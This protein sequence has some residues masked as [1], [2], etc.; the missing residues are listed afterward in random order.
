MKTKL[1]L[2]AFALAALSTINSQLSTAHAQGALTPSGA[3]APTMKTLAQV[4]PRTD[5]L[6]L[7]AGL[8]GAYSITQPGSY[9][10]SANLVSAPGV[11]GIEVKTNDVTIDL[12]GFALNGAGGIRGIAVNGNN[13][14]RL[15]VRNGKIT[16]YTSGIDG[17]GVLGTN[18]SLT[19]EDVQLVGF[20]GTGGKGI[21]GGDGLQVRRCQIST[22]NGNQGAAL[23]A[24]NLAQISD[25]LAQNNYTGIATGS[26]S[27]LRAVVARAHTTAFGI[28]VG[29]D[30]Q[31]VECEAAVNGGDGIIAGTGSRLA[32]C[33]AKKNSASGISIGA[34]VTVANCSALENSGQAGIYGSDNC[35]IRDC[36][37][38]LNLGR[39]I[40]AS[41]PASIQNCT[42]SGNSSRGIETGGYITGCTASLNGDTGIYVYG[43]NGRVV[44]NQCDGNLGATS[45]GIYVATAGVQVEGNTVTSQIG[46]GILIT[47][48]SANC[49][50]VANKAHGNGT[51]YLFT[52]LTTTFGS[53][54]T[55]SGGG[56]TNGVGA[57]ANFSY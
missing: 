42:V 32:H 16:G 34:N 7:S 51:N 28:F 31:L 41:P 47:G 12:R 53:I 56:I 27:L 29:P 50:V 36:I 6:T 48:G 35:L 26:N 45:A 1:L 44:N 21:T 4:E 46:T 33:L 8:N 18:H 30:S 38:N 52:P 13:F 2:T 20:S 14:Q 40:Q 57:W 22:F 15:A 23:T 19:V 11:S 37:A 25:C 43:L 55:L 17:A 49:L 5:I 9:F 3:P 54:I 24:G 39:G 10:L